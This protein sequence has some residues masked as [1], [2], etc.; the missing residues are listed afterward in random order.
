M[1]ESPNMKR[2]FIVFLTLSMMVLVPQLLASF[3]CQLFEGA[4]Y[5]DALALFITIAGIW[6]PVV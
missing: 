5:R 4:S 6:I 1:K 3:A 2:T